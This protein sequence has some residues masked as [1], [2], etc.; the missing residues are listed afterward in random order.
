MTFGAAGFTMFLC[1]LFGANATAIKISLAGLGVF[2]TATIRFGCAAAVIYLW[3]TL[4]GRP[5][6]ISFHQLRLMLILGLIFYVQLTLFYLGLSRTTASH[7]TL[8]SNIL[9]FVVLVLAHFFLKE[10][11]ISTRKV[12]GLILGFAGVLILLGDAGQLDRSALQGDL[13]VLAAVLVWGCNAIYTKRIISTFHPFQITLYP[14]AIAT[15]LFLISALLVD[16]PMIGHVDGQILI[17]LF[18]QT[19]VTASFGM[20]GWMMMIKRYG[21]TTLHSFI[22]IMPISGVFFGVMLLGEPLTANLAGA[23]ALVT[24][25]LVIINRSPRRSGQRGLFHFIF[26]GKH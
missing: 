5:V 24:V 23:I 26:P 14:L 8:I 18:Y 4:S 10:E 15:P 2:T 16:R 21:A 11:Q 17:S 25:G 3:A 19:F 9:P 12:I 20:I 6:R 7:G 1:I 13:F 22:F